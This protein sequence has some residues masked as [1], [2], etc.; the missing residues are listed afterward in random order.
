MLTLLVRANKRAIRRYVTIT[1]TGNPST[2]NEESFRLRNPSKFL[3][4]SEMSLPV[5][6][7]HVNTPITIVVRANKRAIRRYIIITLT[8]N[9]STVNED[10]LRLRNP[11]KFL[12]RREM[13]L[14]ERPRS[15]IHVESPSKE[16]VPS[17]P[18]RWIMKFYV[19]SSQTL[20]FARFLH[21]H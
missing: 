3:D 19:T 14:P 13:P 21:L 2:V 4:R 10:S 8:G 9:P 7:R 5:R 17:L 1:L 12:E 6:P 16:A 11:S 18:L 20:L 15:T